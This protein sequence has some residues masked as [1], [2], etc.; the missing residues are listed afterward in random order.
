MKGMVFRLPIFLMSLF[1]GLWLAGCNNEP[2]AEP[3]SLEKT[4][5]EEALRSGGLGLHLPAFEI[6]HGKTERCSASRG[7]LP[8]LRREDEKGDWLRVT[9]MDEGGRMT[10]F[11]FSF[12]D[13]ARLADM[14]E[15]VRTFLPTD[16][17]LVKTYSI[18]SEIK[19]IES[20]Y[21]SP[22]D[23]YHSTWLEQRLPE[24]AWRSISGGGGEVSGSRLKLGTFY[25]FY[26]EHGASMRLGQR[27]QW[28]H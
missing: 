13:S 25:V 14:R 26:S 2:K 8:C 19:T 23:L 18:D 6:H 20:L 17:R 24:S 12:A 22:V 9:R 15:V 11:M 5:E 16:S 3:I 28:R 7:N 27:T 10:D 21:D 4:P 1:V